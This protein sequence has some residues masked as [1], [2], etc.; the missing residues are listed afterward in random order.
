MTGTDP[1]ASDAKLIPASE[2]YLD[3]QNP[4]LT[5]HDFSVADQNE[6]L[7]WL[8]KERNVSEITDSI[9]S[10]RS[11][12]KHEPLIAA[13]EGGK[14]IVIEG[15]RRL[16]AVKLLL[17]ADLQRKIEATGV[18]SIDD[19]LRLNISTLPVLEKSRK[20]VWDFVGFKHVNGPQEWDSIAKA[21]YIARIHDDFEIPL[22]KIA[23]TIGD[24]NDTVLRLYH[25][26]C[27]L[28]Q[29]KD[30]GVFKLEDRWNKKTRFAYSHL[31]TGLGYSGIQDYLGIK[32]DGKGKRNPVP[33]KKVVRL[34]KL[35]LWMYGNESTP[36]L[37]RSQNPDLRILDE[38]LRSRRGQAALERGLSLQAAYKASRG[39]TSL[40]REAM[41]AAEQNLREAKGYVTTGYEGQSD[42]LETAENAQALVNSL[43][44]E[45]RNRSKAPLRQRA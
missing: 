25:G 22:E 5:G 44:D 13:R 27:V 17:S 6:I 42:I 29:A 20:E 19:E 18:P 34:G 41:V 35:C 21:E 37:I 12:W 28:R 11:F 40:L 30:A 43:L 1:V 39:D 9:T 31:W 7:K 16:A 32:P 24:R 14:L 38:A 8:W 3:P 15:N 10:T 36:P 23:K 4:R 33:K 45:M 2:L 26:Y